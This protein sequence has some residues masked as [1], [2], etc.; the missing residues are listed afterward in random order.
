MTPEIN[1]LVERGMRTPNM[2]KVIIPY[3][4]IVITSGKHQ[5][6]RINEA[7]DT[8]LT[9]QIENM[10]LKNPIVVMPLGDTGLFVPNSGHT[11]YKSCKEIV[12]S[13]PTTAKNHGFYDGMI[14]YAYP[15]EITNMEEFFTI[16]Q[17]LNDH[18]QANPMRRADLVDNI[19]TLF[20][21]GSFKA[22][23]G[24]LDKNATLAFLKSMKLQNF[25]KRGLDGIIQTVMSTFAK[26]NRLTFTEGAIQ[27]FSNKSRLNGRLFQK[28]N[29]S[30]NASSDHYVSTKDGVV[31]NSIRGIQ[32]FNSLWV[33]EHLAAFADYQLDLADHG[34]IA[35]ER[36]L[37]WHVTDIVESDP[38]DTAL[39]CLQKTRLNLL[40]I[41]RKKMRV[42]IPEYRPTKI[43]FI[44]QFQLEVDSNG[45][46]V[47][48][49]EVTYYAV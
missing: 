25:S 1:R 15:E 47:Y 41:A 43:A 42:I 18:E 36:V 37:Y 31:S 45:N 26:E 40:N 2:V 29:I 16:A 44:P 30:K 13:S 38:E 4:K 14:C 24:S 8:T 6:R 33:S 10:G 48:G 17:V 11:R 46:E 3:D 22:A 20:S 34:V 7:E 28:F 21:A 39:E 35:T 9:Y 12:D 19:M 23:D 32:P 27:T 5:V 49:E